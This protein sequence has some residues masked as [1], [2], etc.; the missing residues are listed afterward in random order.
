MDLPKNDEKN[1]FATND[2]GYAYMRLVTLFLSKGVPKLSLKKVWADLKN[3][4]FVLFIYYSDYYYDR[5][6]YQLLNKP[7]KKEKKKCPLNPLKFFSERV[8]GPLWT[9]KVFLVEYIH[10]PQHLLKT[11]F[12]HFFSGFPFCRN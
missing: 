5:L 9:K 1:W 12:C 2:A 11:N 8:W 6:L 3:I 10:T 4:F 7:E